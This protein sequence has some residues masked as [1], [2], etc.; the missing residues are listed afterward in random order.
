MNIITPSGK[1]YAKVYLD[2]DM[3]CISPSRYNY[4]Y[5]MKI[6]AKVIPQLIAILKDLEQNNV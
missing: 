6:D 2:G 1:V 3:F 5:S 4:E